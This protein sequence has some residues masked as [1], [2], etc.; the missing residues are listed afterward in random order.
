[1]AMDEALVS[2]ASL[3]GQTVVAAAAT[4]GWEAVKRGVARLLGRG[5]AAG[6]AV[7]ER[8]LEQV[9]Q[10][11]AGVSAGQVEVV[12]ER[13]AAAWRVR[14]LDLLEEQPEIADR[15]RALV[16]QASAQLPTGDV[17]AEDH[18]I[19]AGRDVT[20]SASS[21]GVAAGTVHGN[22]TPTNPPGPGSEIS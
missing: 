7:A 13:M 17:S 8:R 11:L 12:R 4:D 2:L 5:D 16:E 21:G 18:G 1:M 20:I 14:L 19:A 9:R 3:A 15:L 10:E 22:V 6:T